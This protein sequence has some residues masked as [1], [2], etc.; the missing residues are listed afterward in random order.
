MMLRQRLETASLAGLWL[1]AAV[2]L[3]SIA[4]QNIIFLGMA[5]WLGLHLWQ[6]SFP[7]FPKTL[8]FAL[9]FL[10]LALIACLKSENQSH[11]LET[12]KRWLL[13]SAAFYASTALDTEKRLRPVLGALVFFSGIICLGSA[14]W[15]FDGPIHALGSQSWAELLKRWSEEGD[16]RAHAGSGGYM[17]LGTSSM[18]ALCFG[19]ALA[20]EEPRYRRPLPLLCLAFCA[21]AL[22]LS[23]TRSAWLGALAGL[24]LLL[25]LRK[26]RLALWTLAGILALVVLWPSNPFWQ[27]AEAGTDFRQESLRERLFMR[28]AA[29]QISMRHPLWGI[30]DALESWDDAA[31]HHDGY[32]VR[33]QSRA[34]ELWGFPADK[35]Q[36]H[37]H[38]DWLQLKVMYGGP[39]AFFFG[40]FFVL[41]GLVFLSRCFS[42]RPVVRALGWGGLSCLIAWW[43]NGLYEFNFGSFQSSFNFWFLCGLALA[44]R[45]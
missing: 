38:N 16:W 43:V 25:S 20:L 30:G 28:Q 19:T 32:Y 13:I 39:A 23:F 29:E 17:V 37:L 8:F 36:G 14:L 18:L 24:G 31:G 42:A 10:F 11:S 2:A 1:F 3:L 26:P 35:E 33:T 40:A 45:A 9:P 5:A 12:Y 4:A 21:L 7:R 44:G 22:A 6:G 41:L 27:R 15:A 34:A